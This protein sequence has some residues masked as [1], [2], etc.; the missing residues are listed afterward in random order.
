MSTPAALT[1]ELLPGPLAVCRLDAEAAVPAW[2][3]GAVTSVTRTPAE[4]SVVC[5]EEAVPL[6]I[7]A[8]RGFRCLAV[9]GRLDFSLP[10]VIAS[11]SAPLAAAR[12]SIFVVSTF[13]TD[14]LLVRATQLPQAVAALRD[15]GHT[16]NGI[17]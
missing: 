16:L 3:A 14:L 5:A 11:L 7:K 15:A 12:V 4:L 1:L 6:D 8:E 9:V 17:P 13:D 10:G 2:A